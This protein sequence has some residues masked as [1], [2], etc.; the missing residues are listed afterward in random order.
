MTKRKCEIKGGELG[1]K[2]R[3]KKSAY[4]E[5]HSG[6]EMKALLHLGRYF[7]FTCL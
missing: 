2:E 5:Y 1:S 7:P 4:E 6:D 3:G